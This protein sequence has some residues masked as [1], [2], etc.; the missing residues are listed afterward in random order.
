MEDAEPPNTVLDL[1]IQQEITP[2]AARD[3]LQARD[4]A[5]VTPIPPFRA[6][7]NSAFLYYNLGKEGV[8]ACSSSDNTTYHFCVY[9]RKCFLGSHSFCICMYSTR[10]YIGSNKN[11][12]YAFIL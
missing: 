12:Y 1:N 9:L 4:E 10:I 11:I 6:R 8:C 2:L 5:V 7:G 3:Y